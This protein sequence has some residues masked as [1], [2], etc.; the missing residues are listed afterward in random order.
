MILPAV[1][2]MQFFLMKRSFL[3]EV[4]A[5]RRGLILM[6]SCFKKATKQEWL[7]MIQCRNV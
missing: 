1:L 6:F 5:L 3:N 7:K 4:L 2:N